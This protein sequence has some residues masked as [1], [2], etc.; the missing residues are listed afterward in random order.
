MEQHKPDGLYSTGDKSTA[1]PPSTRSPARY[2]ASSASRASWVALHLRAGS[3]TCSL[4]RLTPMSTT[5]SGRENRPL[6][7]RRLPV[8][9]SGYNIHNSIGVP[10]TTTRVL[11]AD[12]WNASWRSTA[13][14]T[15]SGVARGRTPDDPSEEH[16]PAPNAGATGPV[17][18]GCDRRQARAGP[19][20]PTRQ[21]E[22]AML[23]AMP[24]E[25]DA[26]DAP[27]MEHPADATTYLSEAGTNPLPWSS[28]GE[29]ADPRPRPDTPPACLWRARCRASSSPYTRHDEGMSAN[30]GR[31]CSPR[32]GIKPERGAMAVQTDVL[33]TGHR[34]HGA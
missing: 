11:A 26:P 34:P 31:W 18:E 6:R 1:P 9:V 33:G 30:L 2:I 23:R 27:R 7:G 22:F 19:A 12:L 25:M 3:G 13:D 16:S 14:T 10:A 29:P 28:M 20:W 4:P 17:D 8:L 5:S 21:A 32:E 15:P 24:P